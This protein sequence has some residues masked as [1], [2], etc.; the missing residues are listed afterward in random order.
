MNDLARLCVVTQKAG[1][2]TK[3][4]TTDRLSRVEWAA[5]QQCRGS[6]SSDPM[7]WGRSEQKL[8]LY[9]ALFGYSGAHYVLTVRDADLPQNFDGVKRRQ[10]A[11]VMR[12]RRR[13]PWSRQRVSR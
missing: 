13:C 8:E 11:F 4:Y 3:T 10:T 5:R 6:P 2:L 1:P 7:I 9:L 12:T